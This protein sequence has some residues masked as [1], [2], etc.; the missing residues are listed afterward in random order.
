V[1]HGGNTGEKER[2]KAASPRLMEKHESPNHPPASPTPN[3]KGTPPKKHGRARGGKPDWGLYA[4]VHWDTWAV[5]T[6]K[7]MRGLSG[8]P[9]YRK[10]AVGNSQGFRGRDHRPLW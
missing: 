5:R 3:P 7:A 4:F 1:H 6:D 8:K 9:Y 2:G 10:T